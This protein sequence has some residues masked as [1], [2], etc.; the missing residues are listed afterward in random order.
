MT[1]K[2]NKRNSIDRKKK[3][4]YFGTPS[5][6]YPAVQ[7][8]SWGGIFHQILL[9]LSDFQKR[10]MAPQNEFTTSILNTGHLFDQN[11]RSIL[12]VTPSGGCPAAQ[13]K[14][15]GI[16]KNHQNFDFFFS[17][18]RWMNHNSSSL[19]SSNIQK[20]ERNTSQVWMCIFL[21]ASGRFLAD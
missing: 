9:F 5:G 4:I 16:C 10:K 21:A 20:N 15:A 7:K 18:S 3:C 11:W 1:S 6:G 19:Y 17:F 14:S 8:I 2:M 12:F 13:K